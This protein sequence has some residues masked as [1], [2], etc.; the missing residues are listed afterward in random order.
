MNHYPTSVQIDM[1]PLEAAAA[2]TAPAPAT[3]PAE[4]QKTSSLN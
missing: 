4:P 1:E 3:P 2:A